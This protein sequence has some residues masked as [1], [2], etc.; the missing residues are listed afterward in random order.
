MAML[1]RVTSLGTCQDDI[2][3][4]HGPLVSD[5]HTQMQFDCKVSLQGSSIERRRNS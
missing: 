5:K 4:E 2:L 1:S 3:T